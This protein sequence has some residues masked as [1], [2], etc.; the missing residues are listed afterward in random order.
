M[1]IVF[2][3]AQGEKQ[4]LAA[5]DDSLESFEW[6]RDDARAFGFSSEARA[7]G[8]ALAHMGGCEAASVARDWR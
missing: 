4:F 2:K 8:V 5:A 3:Q 7:T 1:Y 6:T